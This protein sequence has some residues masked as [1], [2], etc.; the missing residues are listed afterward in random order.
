MSRPTRFNPEVAER[1]CTRIAEGR[2]IRQACVGEGLP[3][4]RTLMRWLS[5]QDAE[6]ADGKA[7][8]EPG[9]YEAL[10]Q[11]YARACEIRADARFEAMD[12]VLYQVRQGKMDAAAGR[13]HLDAI[14][15]QTAKENPKKYGDAFTVRGDKSAPLEVRTTA[16]D[17]T[18]DQLAV[19]A[20]GGLRAAT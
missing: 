17:L 9:P 7:R 16:K 3:H 2:S 20:A 10:R 8:S 13:L 19:L 12:H 4:W 11:Q 14:K 1:V 5:T 15:W 18:D 6:P